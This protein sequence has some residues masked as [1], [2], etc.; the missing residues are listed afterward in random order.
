MHPL[1]ESLRQFS[2][3]TDSQY[4]KSRLNKLKVDETVLK[5]LYELVVEENPFDYLYLAIVLIKNIESFTLNVA[6]ILM[7]ILEKYKGD[8]TCSLLFNSLVNVGI[9]TEKS[10]ELV[11]NLLKID[12]ELCEHA[13]ACLLTGLYC[14]KRDEKIVSDYLNSNH[15]TARKAA[16][17]VIIYST[18]E[19]ARPVTMRDQL[20]E[21]SNIE[22]IDPRMMEL[23]PA[24]LL[25]VSSDEDGTILQRAK[26]LMKENDNAKLGVLTHPYCIRH[27]NQLTKISILAVCTESNDTR[28]HQRVIR[29]IIGL[30]QE[31][32][33]SFLVKLALSVIDKHIYDINVTDYVDV[34]EN[35]VPKQSNETY[36]EVI[37]WVKNKP[38]NERI[39]IERLILPHILAT[40]GKSSPELLLNY[41]KEHV[42]DTK[43]I[44]RVIHRLLGRLHDE[45]TESCGEFINDCLEYLVETAKRN[46]ITPEN[47][48]KAEQKKID[49]CG[50]LLNALLSEKPSPDVEI[51][52]QNVQLFPNIK[53]FLGESL[54][55]TD[56]NTLLTLLSA[57]DLVNFSS[58]R[59]QIQQ[60]EDE[61][62]HK[63]LLWHLSAVISS[64]ALLS[65]IEELVT[66]LDPKEKG[67]INLRKKL[68]GKHFYEGLSELELFSRLKKAGIQFMPYPQV[69]RE[70]NGSVKTSVADALIK[71]GNS[72]ILVEIITPDM[73][74]DLKYWHSA[75]LKNRLLNKIPDEYRKHFKGMKELKDILIVVDTSRSHEPFYFAEDVMKGP[76]QIV[77]TNKG[78]IVA[79]SLKRKEDGALSK[80]CSEINIVGIIVYRRDLISG[81]PW[82]VTSG[83]FY[84]N[85]YTITEDKRKICKK[86][87]KH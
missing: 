82:V 15:L 28:V 47:I 58:L 43:L 10:K 79:V 29:S 24:A 33:T 55:Q 70:E 81:V 80:R 83:A 27:L 30:K 1:K 11:N 34:L 76:E 37:K 35:L 64:L 45:H 9:R 73:Q 16:L 23:L 17:R 20:L 36:D 51:A 72:E 68:C 4:I 75:K 39:R 26:T 42:D 3:Q 84:E 87:L 71:R 38:P 74:K 65:Y 40:I 77:C 31:V 69:K 57:E 5:A 86:S 44:L 48:I 32:E 63:I 56:Q 54:F 2:G 60:I 6:K 52:K 46:G 67:I 8:M 21:F 78:E 41:M 13:V 59:E 62:K 18:W 7:A 12:S 53:S 19:G 22:H 14:S 50:A 49:K 61:K 25:C 85:P 66:Q